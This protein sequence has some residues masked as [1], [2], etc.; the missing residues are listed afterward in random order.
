M[1]RLLSSRLFLKIFSWI[2]LILASFFWLQIEERISLD[3]PNCLIKCRYEQVDHWEFLVLSI[4]FLV[5]TLSIWFYLGF[6]VFK[7]LRAEAEAEK[8]NTIRR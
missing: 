7:R 3:G 1:Q 5:I 6:T 2:S 4:V 8:K